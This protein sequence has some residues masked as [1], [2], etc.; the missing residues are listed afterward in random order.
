SIAK[1]EILE[2]DE[3]APAYPWLART[4][5]PIGQPFGYINDGFY[6]DEADILK[7]ARPN[8]PVNTIHPGDLK[9]RD[10]NEDGIIDERDMGPIGSPDIPTTS[11][12]LTLGAQYKGL[13]LSVLFQG[14]FGY[15]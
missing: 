15:S 13:S 1:N 11:I 4:G 8:I 9:Y 14:A 7:S 6:A 3:S 12:G 5:N 10:L 2:I